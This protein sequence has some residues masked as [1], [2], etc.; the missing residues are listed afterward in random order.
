MEIDQ[1]IQNI[2]NKLHLVLKKLQQVQAENA[3]LKEQVGSQ[4]QEIQLQYKAIA[5]MENRLKTVAIA[6][7]AHSQSDDNEAFKKEIRGKINEYI[8]EIDRCIALLSA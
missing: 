8:R 4:E 7:A 5:E 6:H 1:Y 3:L 2:E